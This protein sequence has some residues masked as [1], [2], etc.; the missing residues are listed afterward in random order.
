MDFLFFIGF[1][2]LLFMHLKLSSRVQACEMMLKKKGNAAP[3]EIKK[4]EAQQEMIAPP[5]PPILFSEDVIEKP[6]LQPIE[7]WKVPEKFSKFYQLIKENWMAVFGSIAVVIGAVCFGLTSKIMQLPEARVAVL[8]GGSLLCLWISRKTSLLSGCL[9]SIAGAVMLFAAYGAGQIPGLSFIHHPLYALMFLCMAIGFNLLLAMTTAVQTIAS[10]HVILSL[11][12]FCLVPQNVIL[13]PL[14][15]VVAVTGLFTA[16]RLKWDVHLLL[17]V[18]AFFCFN[19]V[20]TFS[21]TLSTWEHQLA[22]GC[23]LVVGM[24]GG[25]IHYSK[26]YKSPHFEILSLIAHLSNWLLLV[27]NLWLH[28]HYF[29]GTSFVLGAIAIGGFILA[30]RAKDKDIRWLYHTDTLISQIIAMSAIVSLARYAFNPLDLC[31]LILLE[32]FVFNVICLKQ[33]ED[34]LLRMGYILQSIACFITAALVLGVMS[35]PGGFEKFPMM[36]RLSLLTTICWSFHWLRSTK[37]WS[38]DDYRFF[39]FKEENLEKPYS[40]TAML[41]T[42][43]FLC[44]FFIDTQNVALQSVILLAVFGLGYWRKSNEDPTLNLSFLISL[45][46]LHLTNWGLMFVTLF[47]N[48]TAR[49]IVVPLG[50][51]FLDSLFIFRNYLR[52]NLWNKNFHACV[53]YALGIQTAFCITFLTNGISLLIP[54]PI[55]LGFSLLAL[56][57]IRYMKKEIQDPFLHVGLGFLLLFLI[58]FSTVSLQVDPMWHGLS[59]R[60]L[61]EILAIGSFLYW[62]IYYPQKNNSWTANRLVDVCLAFST[63]CA[64]VETPEI[65]RP[66]IWI[67]T[68]IGLLLGVISF[69]WPKRLVLYSWAYFIASTIHVAFVTSSLSPNH[70][71]LLIVVILQFCYFYIPYLKQKEIEAVVYDRIDLT[72][73]FPIFLEIALL[74]AFNFEKAILTLLWVGLTCVYLSIGL[75]QKSKLSIQISMAA[76]LM[77]SFRLIF[78]D[79]HQSDLALRSL[80]FIGVG[81]LM[82]GFSMIYKK[83]KYRIEAH[84]QI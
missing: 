17:I 23:S 22:M 78:F 21:Q 80:V 64:F 65:W 11:L 13:M 54:G 67:V 33:K 4:V 71:S 30:R 19:L 51:I 60:L 10:L 48:E 2:T 79:M 35:Q 82:L 32:T 62:I 53:V 34:Y 12:A 46:F 45:V 81:A 43:F 69:H 38:P 70:I 26:K 50:L 36:V 52:F 59:L 44:L 27:A 39:L 68:S 56:E 5:P 73:L 57:A 25:L 83:F 9:S 15:M 42:L 6:V 24:S 3:F 37:R 41:G 66:I 20:W 55:F 84:E 77:C 7:D 72:I 14:A 75:L 74:F 31:L 28:A 16:Y 29:K 49:G 63:F 18:L 61:T 40:F 76:L 58:R 47:Q 1:I 8:I